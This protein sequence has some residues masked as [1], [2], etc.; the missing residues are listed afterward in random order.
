M[1]SKFKRALAFTA[2]LAMCSMTL[3]NFPNGTFDISLPVMAAEGDVAVDE[4]NFPD[5]IFRTY[6]DE[7]FDT[8]DD[9]VL[10]AAEIAAVT[11]IDLYYAGI[12]T[13]ADLTGVEYFTALTYLDCSSNQLQSLDLSKNAA[14]EILYCESNQLTSLDVS[15]NAELTRLD[16][17]FNQLTSL[18]VSKNTEL[19]ELL[20]DENELTALDISKNL[21]LERLWVEYNP[22]TELDLSQHT[23]LKNL[24]CY[25]TQLTS[26][27]VSN[28]TALEILYCYNNSYD[29]DLIGGTFDLS[30][31]PEGFD[32]TKASE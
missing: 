19:K 26:L 8:T 21:K 30:T 14:L 15:N 25:G 4:V 22:L 29:I 12:T 16:C 10:D 17:Y 18:D 7:N 2:S 24:H 11:E 31:L 3:L 6:V 13:I 20:C 27:D 32:I 28:N 5:E 9:N 1:R 23:A